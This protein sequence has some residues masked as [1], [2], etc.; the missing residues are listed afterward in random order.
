MRKSVEIMESEI[1]MHNIIFLHITCTKINQLV[2][3]CHQDMNPVILLIQIYEYLVNSIIQRLAGK[4][5][6]LNNLCTLIKKTD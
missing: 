4:A 1:T 3:T 5:R 2:R 6:Q